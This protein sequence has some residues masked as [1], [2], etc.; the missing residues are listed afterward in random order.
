MLTCTRSAEHVPAH[1]DRPACLVAPRHSP[2][3]R[4]WAC[5]CPQSAVLSLQCLLK[6]WE[7]CLP[8]PSAQVVPILLSLCMSCSVQ[9]ADRVVH[10]QQ[11]VLERLSRSI[12]ETDKQ[13]RD[14]MDTI[15]QGFAERRQEIAKLTQEKRW[16][17]SSH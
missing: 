5:S 9:S 7:A 15:N 12:I 13:H 14:Q 16:G 6:A 8:A 2:K 3:L 10:T 4:C 1:A 11:D 17:Q